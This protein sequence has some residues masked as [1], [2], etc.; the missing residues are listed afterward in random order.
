MN[1]KVKIALQI[2]ILLALIVYLAIAVFKTD[3]QSTTTVCSEVDITVKDSAELNY[4]T[5]NDIKGMLKYDK[6]YPQGEKM[7]RV[8]CKAIEKLLHR[9]QYIKV[10]NCY[11]TSKGKVVI[12]V[13]QKKP[14]IRIMAD[15]GDDYFLDED[16]NV[17]ASKGHP[18]NLIIATGNIDK[19]FA[20]STVLELAK[21]FQNDEFWNDQIE[22]IDVT[23]EHE[24]RL[25]PRVGDHVAFLGNTDD[26][27][28]KL[29]RLRQFYKKILGKV[30]WNKY[31]LIS[32][33][34]SN[35]IICTKK[36]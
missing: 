19:K 5:A 7:S 10:V 12:D 14:I 13:T 1:K 34:F 26:L 22:Q 30:G 4:I 35:Q 9:Q 15:N 24:L 8:D 11:K 27:E 23:P 36:E 2:L 18:S 6:L 3:D 20:K 28:G 32:V 17:L 16:A 21:L 31:S 29:T 33:E 25:V